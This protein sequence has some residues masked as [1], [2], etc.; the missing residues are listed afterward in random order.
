MERLVS[1]FVFQRILVGGRIALDLCGISVLGWRSRSLSTAPYSVCIGWATVG[2]QKGNCV[3]KGI[4]GGEVF[5]KSSQEWFD[6]Q[7]LG[8]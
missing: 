4:I 8:G 3:K 6:V 2:I 5:R 7:G 1:F